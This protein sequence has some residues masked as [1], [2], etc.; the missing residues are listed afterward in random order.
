LIWECVQAHERLHERNA[1]GAAVEQIFGLFFRFVFWLR[2]SRTTVGI[3]AVIVLT[4][5]AVAVK[6]F[7]RATTAAAA[8]VGVATIELICCRIEV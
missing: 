2:S 8:A 6:L 4:I 7:S 5:A 3:I 1:I